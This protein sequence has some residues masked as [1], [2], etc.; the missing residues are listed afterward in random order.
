M[1]YW[2]FEYNSLASTEL[3]DFVISFA[4]SAVSNNLW[5][6]LMVLI[7]LLI[8]YDFCPVKVG[9]LQI[10]DVFIAKTSIFHI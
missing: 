3:S 4:F 8:R 1:L 7:F 5:K 10:N 2:I 9:T 6:S